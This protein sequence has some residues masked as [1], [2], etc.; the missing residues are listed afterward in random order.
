[1]LKSYSFC[2]DSNVDS[3]MY[4]EIW[5]VINENKAYFYTYCRGEAEEAMEKTLLHCLTHY[6]P[7]LGDLKFYILALARDIVRHKYKVV[8]VD[9]LES[10]LESADSLEERS[11]TVHLGNIR[12]FSSDVIEN[13]FLNVDRH[14]EVIDLALSNIPMFL[15]MCESIKSVDSSVSYYSKEFKRECLNLMKRIPNFTNVCLQLYDK[16]SDEMQAFWNGLDGLEKQG[17]LEADYGRIKTSV[18]K[19]VIF[20]DTFGNSIMD[21][22]RQDYTVRGKMGDKLIVRVNYADL[23]NKMCMWVQMEQ[24]PIRYSVEDRF[25]VRTFGGSITLPNPPLINIKELLKTEIVTNIVT[26]YNA[27][28]INIGSKYIYLLVS[29]IKEVPKRSFFGFDIEL[30]CEEISYETN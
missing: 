10:T 11:P 9:F 13:L 23:L 28:Y 25:I 18:S 22:D 7:N 12:D 16:Y 21:A 17:W 8:P 1:M 5:K 15:N 4:Y 3:N 26:D 19:K 20:A 14:T 30:P 6:N 27:K 29:E 2:K 24:S